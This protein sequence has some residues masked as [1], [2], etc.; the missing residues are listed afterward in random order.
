MRS[1]KNV[2]VRRIT[3]DD[4]LTDDLIRLLICSLSEGVE[5][6]SD[7]DTEWENE[8]EVYVR[9][10]TYAQE[11]DIPSSKTQP[12]ETFDEGQVF[13]SGEFEVIGDDEKAPEGFKVSPGRKEF[14]RIDN[15]KIFKE[16]VK[17][18]YSD[19]LKGG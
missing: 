19:T 5:E 6:F 1:Q 15:L 14:L 13:L 9:P 2:G 8:G 18:L 3:V 10:E 17:R 11:L 7:L 16:Q 4:Q 12:W